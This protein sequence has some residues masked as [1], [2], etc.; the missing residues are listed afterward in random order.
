[1]RTWGYPRSVRLGTGLT[2]VGCPQSARVWSRG[3]TF[4]VRPAAIALRGGEARDSDSTVGWQ[5][6]RLAGRQAGRTEYWAADH[7]RS[8]GRYGRL[9]AQRKALP[10]SYAVRSGWRTAG[11]TA[12]LYL[13]AVPQSCRAGL[14][15]RVGRRA[16]KAAPPE[17]G[18]A[19]H[20]MP[21]APRAVPQRS[22]PGQ[23]AGRER[24]RTVVPQGQYG[25]SGHWM[26]EC[27]VREEVPWVE[28]SQS[29]RV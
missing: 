12:R 21:A 16:E 28:I 11:P 19:D 22:W 6:A 14:C 24:S 10:E 29:P 25:R 26:P 13:R 1:V 17:G 4:A 23:L 8:A 2:C 7:G 3:V 15:R 27:R 20:T 9:V 5:N 18:S